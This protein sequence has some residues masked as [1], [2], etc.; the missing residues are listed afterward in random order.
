MGYSREDFEAELKALEDMKH[1][2]T[3]AYLNQMMEWVA[4]VSMEQDFIA[5]EKR[6]RGKWGA[7]CGAAASRAKEARKQATGD[8]HIASNL[9]WLKEIRK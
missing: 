5:Q 9:K 2:V 3:E 1:I 4:F 6:I 7:I 8:D